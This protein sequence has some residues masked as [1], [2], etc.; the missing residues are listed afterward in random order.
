VTQNTG[1]RALCDREVTAVISAGL[2]MMV[3]ALAALVMVVFTPAESTTTGADQENVEE[4]VAP[5]R[6]GFSRV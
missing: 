6:D 4:P 1:F 5:K 2:A 3:L